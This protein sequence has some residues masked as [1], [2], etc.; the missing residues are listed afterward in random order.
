[1]D[2]SHAYAIFCVNQPENFCTAVLGNLETFL[3]THA[4]FVSTTTSKNGGLAAILGKN[5]VGVAFLP[6]KR[7]QERTQSHP[8]GR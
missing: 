3:Q 5:Y 1:M 6:L 8:I 7:R 2:L 4:Q